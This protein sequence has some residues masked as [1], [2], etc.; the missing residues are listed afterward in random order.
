MKRQQSPARDTGY[1]AGGSRSFIWMIAG[2][3]LGALALYMFDPI[4]GRR[5]RSLVKDKGR[6]LGKEAMES[7][8]GQY[9]D[10]K[11]RAQGAFEEAKESVSEVVQNAGP[12]VKD[13]TLVKRVRSKIGRHVTDP[14]SIEVEAH[15]GNVVLNGKILQKE[16]DPLIESVRKVTGVS[17]I[18]NHLEVSESNSASSMHL[19]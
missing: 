5:R 12:H 11:N 9:E 19:Q 17:N 18:E 13:E 14:N 1:F 4:S 3:C 16:I 2:L 15:D 10:I 7:V 8:E 6:S